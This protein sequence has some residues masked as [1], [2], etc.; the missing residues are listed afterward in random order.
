MS[1]KTKTVSQTGNKAGKKQGKVGYGC[2]PVEYQW[3]PGQSGNAKGLE[4][5]TIS[6][7]K[8]VKKKLREHPDQA[9]T[10]VDKWIIDA[11]DGNDKARQSLVEYIDGKVPDKTEIVSMMQIQVVHI[12]G[13]A[14][15]RALLQSGIPKAQ[16]AE[17]LDQMDRL[18]GDGE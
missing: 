17:V 4:P 11:M 18:I 12:I 16:A 15:R 8:M 9:N 6:L 7:V 3:Q 1:K 10:I 14:L 13:D 5:G 2:P